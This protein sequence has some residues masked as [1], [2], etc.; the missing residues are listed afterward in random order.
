MINIIFY[1]LSVW[2]LTHI[3]VSA[4]ILADLRNWLLIFF[5]F[6]GEML[7]CYQC[8]SFWASLIL[9]LFFENLEIGI[10]IFNPLWY[11]IDLSP[12]IWAFIGSGVISFLAVALSAMI[13]FTKD[14]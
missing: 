8:T 14:K 1:L 12:I 10:K 6:A 9:Y 7:E 11:T 2:G 5:P 13:K 4:K 3:L